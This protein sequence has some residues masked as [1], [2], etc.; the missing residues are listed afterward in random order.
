MAS[1]SS[2]T[3]VEPRAAPAQTVLLVA[4]FGDPVAVD[5]AAFACR[6]AG[7]SVA[8]V[9]DTLSEFAAHADAS[10]AVVLFLPRRLSDAN[11]ATL[12]ALLTLAAQRRAESVILVSSALVHLGDEDAAD[13]ETYAYRRANGL[14]ARTVIVRA[15]HVLSQHS[16]VSAALRRVG[17]CFP[18]VPRRLRS[19]C[20][21]GD[22]LFAL[23]EEVRQAPRT[24]RLYTLLG[25]NRPW[26]ERLAEHRPRGPLAV[27]LT[28]ICAVL[29]LLLIGHLAALIF[30]L[31]AR[32][33]P[34]L[35]AWHFDTLRPRSLRELVALA[36][37]YNRRYVKVVG[38]NNGV[39]HFGHRYPGRT[40]VSTVNCDRVARAGPDAIRADGG[41]TVRKVLDFLAGSQELYVI[42][43]YSYVCLGTAFFVPIH[44]SAADFSTIA[45]T[46]TQ[47]V[48]Y[49]PASD[50]VTRSG[51][52]EP[53]FRE[54]LY[55]L[56]SDVVVLQLRLRVK[57]KSRYFLR[58]EELE[59]PS[60]DD[61]LR[62][63]RDT[64]ATNV[65]VRKS[66]AGDSKVQL[67]KFYNDPGD[68]AG[69]VLELPRDRLGRLWDRLEENPVTSFLMHA[70]T[71][72]LAYHVELFFSDDE[73]RTFWETCHSLPLRKIQLRH[74][75]RDGFPH[76]PFR[77][78]DCVS[79]DLFMFR[80]HRHRFEAYLKQTFGTVRSNPGKHST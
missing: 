5:Y 20:V 66:R 3:P 79:A 35:R 13:V 16:R 23:I 33:R 30:S 42:P 2:S 50:G 32:R 1:L 58:K 69:P 8:A 14:R 75:R 18:L 72:H 7:D 59:G 43:N 22:E 40:I 48:L 64:Q 6:R 54:H 11:C 74:I 37:P 21:D 4:G 26:C 68:T 41:A 80:R 34:A 67:Y 51:R 44:G 9:A 17:A 27:C 28:A 38:Y 61:L 31:L 10:V 24:R 55:N 45:D 63:L 78:H 19:C 47:V 29:S 39:T 73:F 56:K 12:D 60:A 70:L 46:I 76:S 36:N 52:D 15:G 77:D 71:R 49:D 65:E 53:L 25:P 62:A 57:P